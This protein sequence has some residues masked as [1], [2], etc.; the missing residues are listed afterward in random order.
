MTMIQVP[1]LTIPKTADELLAAEEA[2][3]GVKKIDLIRLAISEHI[4]KWQALANPYPALADAP[5]DADM[6][7]RDQ[8]HVAALAAVNAAL[9]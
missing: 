7:T 3:T 8:A 1:Y 9:R 4:R 6:D 2:H 5:A